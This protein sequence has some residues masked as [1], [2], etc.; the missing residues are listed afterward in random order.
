MTMDIKGGGVLGGK[1]LCAVCR[2]CNNKYIKCTQPHTKKSYMLTD[3][4]S[5]LLYI[6]NWNPAKKT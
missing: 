6:W 5:Q 4:T 1:D 2:V 3:K